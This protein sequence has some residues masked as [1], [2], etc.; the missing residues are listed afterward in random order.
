MKRCVLAALAALALAFPWSPQTAAAEMTQ[1]QAKKTLAAYFMARPYY[2]VPAACLKIAP[3]QYK[4]RGYAFAV[5]PSACLDAEPGKPDSWRVDA[6]TG[7]VFVRNEAGK[8]LVPV[9]DDRLL[10]ADAAEALVLA[11]PEVQREMKAR[12]N[13]FLMLEGHPERAALASNPAGAFY[14][15]YFGHDMGTHAVRL[16]GFRVNALTREILVSDPVEGTDVSLEAWRG[17]LADD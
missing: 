11:L 14:D 8:Y 5:D 15:F 6:A 9:C 3:G 2:P 10:S 12:N 7:E 1:A 13:A 4:N 17:T 16:W